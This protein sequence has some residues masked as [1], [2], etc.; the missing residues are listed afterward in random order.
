MTFD[1]GSTDARA[2]AEIVTKRPSNVDSPLVGV[3]NTA[4]YVTP[5]ICSAE[6]LR[7]SYS[8]SFILRLVNGPLPDNETAMTR[9]PQ[10]LR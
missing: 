3:P 1:P 8:P 2:H 6:V 7:L 10:H 5:Q 4:E 9:R